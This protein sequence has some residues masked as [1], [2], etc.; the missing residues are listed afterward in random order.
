MDYR[1]IIFEQEGSIATITLNRPKVLNALNLEMVEGILDALGR[2]SVNEDIRA[3]IITGAGRGFCSGDDIKPAAE[4]AVGQ[5]M[6]A[7]RSSSPEG[8]GEDFRLNWHM[9]Y[10]TIRNL[11]KPV[12]AAVNGN[13]HGAGSD[14]MLACD[15]R[16]ASEDAVLGDIRTAHALPIATGACYFMP[17]VLG[18]TKAIELLFTGEL[19][20]AREAERIGLVNKTV[21]ADR[22]REEVT[23]LANRM[24]QGPTKLIG[25]VKEQVYRQLGMDLASAL[26]DGWHDHRDVWGRTEDG[27]EGLRA[28]FEKAPPY[29]PVDS[30]VLPHLALGRDIWRTFLRALSKN[31]R[32]ALNHK[33]ADCVAFET[34]TEKWLA[35]GARADHIQCPTS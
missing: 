9:M 33:M 20:D 1:N 31:M 2:V 12:I 26:E 34:A 18:L 17:R 5:G 35:K 25:R 19:I 28:F 30:V 6:G 21:P 3:L 27:E 14:L 24:A 8:F 13:A 23:E 11:R 10:K 15:F 4:Q 29:I 16:I 7:P 22:F 32:C